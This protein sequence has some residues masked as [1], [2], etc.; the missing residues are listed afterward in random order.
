MLPRPLIIDC[1]LGADDALAL[2]MAFSLPCVFDI[3]GVTTIT[4]NI[5]LSGVTTNALKICELAKRTD[6]RVYEGCSRP[7][8]TKSPLTE[9][10]PGMA[11]L[12][13]ANLPEPAMVAQKEHAVFFIINA[14]L[15]SP[16]PVTVVLMGTLTNMAMALVLNPE[17]KSNIEQIVLMGGGVN[18]G[19]VQ[20]GQAEFNVANDPYA[21]HV[22][23]SSNIPLVMIGLDATHQMHMTPKRLQKIAGLNTKV[24]NEICRIISSPAQRTE[25]LR[26]GFDGPLVH[27]ACTIGYLLRSDLFQGKKCPVSIELVSPL[28]LGRTVV[29]MHHLTGAPA[30]VYVVTDVDHEGLYGLIFKCISTYQDTP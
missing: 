17:I 16:S 18:V 27:D 7:L 20:G 14:V 10:V 15:L 29:D 25:Q 23:F 22:V 19:N 13:G 5:S 12:K 28:T 26:Y 24:G 21:A 1:D 6:V 3:L 4:D 30:S 11:G 9:Y 2:L 8:V